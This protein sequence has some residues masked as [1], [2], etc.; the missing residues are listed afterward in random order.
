MLV[1]FFGTPW[2]PPMN[3]WYSGLI[4]YPYLLPS[5]FLIIAL[6]GKIC[7]DFTRG[8]GF[9]VRTRPMFG[10]G[11]RLFG[12]LYLA[13]MMVR[14][15]IHMSLYPGSLVRRHH[16][17]RFSLYSRELH[18]SLWALPQNSLTKPLGAHIPYAYSGTDNDV[19]RLRSG[20]ALCSLC[21]AIMEGGRRLGT[22]QC[23]ELGSRHGLSRRGLSGRRNIPWVFE[24]ARAVY[25]ALALEDNGL[26][27]WIGQLFLVCGRV[28]RFSDWNSTQMVH[29]RSV[30][31]T[32]GI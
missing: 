21:Q 12:Y 28:V 11:V 8:E 2:L 29:D 30:A 27:D 23:G 1:A 7:L 24:F 16:S 22:A 6:Y 31:P 17:H 18:H 19:D 15:I 26:H 14:Y 9:F 3:A 13:S 20:P 5:Q 32:R 10:Q 4:P 25:P